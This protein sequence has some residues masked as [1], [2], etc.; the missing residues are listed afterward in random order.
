[1]DE[2]SFLFGDAL[3]AGL[4][5][6]ARGKDA[7]IA[8]AFWSAKGVKVL[9]GAQ[10]VGD[11]RLVC[12]IAMGSTSADALRAL[13]AP[14]NELLRHYERLHSKVFLS[15][16]GLVVGSANVSRAAL[17]AD[18]DPA[19]QL[20]AAV[21]HPPGSSVWIAA[22][23]WFDELYK[24][25][26]PVGQ[27]EIDRAGIVYQPPASSIMAAAPRTGSL[28]DIV[29]AAPERFAKISFVVTGAKATE[30]EIIKARISARTLVTGI[31]H[32]AI[33]TW[34]ANS[35]FAGWGGDQVRDRWQRIF[36]EFWLGRRTVS[37]FGY[38]GEV[39][40]AANGSVLGRQD[41]ALVRR[42]VGTAF[43]DRS[44]IGSVDGPLARQLV[45]SGEGALFADGA[46]LATEIA[47][48]RSS[49]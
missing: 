14:R 44:L 24:N 45:K 11:T 17:G 46:E 10:G 48:I 42:T 36:I 28:L 23:A 38:R 47:R 30:E 12:D 25:A 33:E 22:R 3:V 7:R 15:E 43:P 34:P 40:D 35:I 32:R 31:S 19:M 49:N 18:G 16:Q 9:F 5:A 21:F 13:G 20:E 27:A 37:V 29:S 4:Q 41:W 2:S 26:T 39:F 6:V 1:M 8:T